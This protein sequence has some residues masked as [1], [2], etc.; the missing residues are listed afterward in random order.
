MDDDT[1]DKMDS[2]ATVAE[3]LHALYV[4]ELRRSLRP[5]VN[6][7]DRRMAGSPARKPAAEAS[8]RRRAAAR[9]PVQAGR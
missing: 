1:M 2:T 8:R 6:P 7:R 5:P 3:R 9:C 4:D